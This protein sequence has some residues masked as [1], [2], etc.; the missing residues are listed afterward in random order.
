MIGVDERL[1]VFTDSATDTDVGTALFWG[2]SH[3]PT[4]LDV[5]LG[6]GVG[7]GDVF[8]GD[9]LVCEQGVDVGISIGADVAG[10]VCTVDIDWAGQS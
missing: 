2:F 6:I 8:R 5:V 1:C 10:E 4:Q 3:R 7:N 9:G